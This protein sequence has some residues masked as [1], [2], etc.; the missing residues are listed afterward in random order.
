MSNWRERGECP[1]AHG[2]LV[3][4]KKPPAILHLLSEDLLDVGELMGT[5]T[6]EDMFGRI[7]AVCQECGFV[8][9]TPPNH[10]YNYEQGKWLPIPPPEE[11]TE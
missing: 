5:E 2:P 9:T 11:D 3:I 4:F 10:E 8:A 7:I 1:N 6:P